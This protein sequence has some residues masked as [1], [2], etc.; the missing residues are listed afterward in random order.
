MSLPLA[1][2]Q[3]TDTFQTWLTRTNEIISTAA[4]N[5]PE[6]L[7]VTEYA[8]F[9]ANTNPVPATDGSLY[10]DSEKGTLVFQDDGDQQ[11]LGRQQWLK[12]YNSGP[13][14]ITKASPVHITGQYNK[15]P[16]VSPSDASDPTKVYAIGLASRNIPVADYG[17]VVT[18]G[19]VTNI[20]T[21]GL[22]SGQAA[23]VAPGGGLQTTAPPSPNYA[24]EIGTAVNINSANGSIYV[25]PVQH[26]F[27]QLRVGNDIVADGDLTVTGNFSVLGSETITTLT[28]LEVDDT[29]IYLNGG[30]SQVANVALVTG[31]NDLSFKGH[32]NGGN[33][34]TYYVKIDNTSAGS[35][36]TFTW[37]LDNFSTTEQANVAI[38]GTEQLLR[39]GV[40]VQFISNTG[41][42]AGD[43]W[44]T[45]AAPINVDSGW[46]SNRN[47]GH[48]GGGYTHLGVFFDVTDQ[49][50]KF[51]DSYDPEVSGSIDVGHSS[52]RY[53]SVEADRFIGAGTNLTALNASELGTGTVPIARLAGSGITLGTH[54]TGNYVATVANTDNNV[55]VTGSGSANAAVTIG[56]ANDISISGELTAQDVNSTSDLRLKMN[57]N[58]IEGALDKVL[59]L[60]G[61]EFDWIN[62]NKRSIGVVAQQVE[63]VLPEL[64][65]TNDSGYKSVSYGNLTALLIEAIKELK[66]IV[67]DK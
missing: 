41:H 25:E 54:T 33:N 21:S 4:N 50:F 23:H 24:H 45:A 43:I 53:G 31:L 29:F 36:D 16:V 2:V 5:T 11:S 55:V 39:W 18:H 40:S 63:E 19:L 46:A 42:T 38:N 51:F 30:D 61:V 59:K 64:V 27:E 67:D 57:V 66:T 52:F 58:P 44:S 1:N 35:P 26:Y 49:T 37:S 47:V 28:N 34:V 56:L 15:C 65:H 3:T 32:Y 20:D 12:V 17:Y 8:V 7:T 62:N 48:A 60:A 13:G 14:I 9:A 22:T 6:T 10:Y